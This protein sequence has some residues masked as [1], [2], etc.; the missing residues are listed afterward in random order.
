MKSF[1]A[2]Q[3]WFFCQTSLIENNK[4]KED[5]LR[6]H[7]HPA[8]CSR[9]EFRNRGKPQF[10]FTVSVL[11]TLTCITQHT[12]AAALRPIRKTKQLCLSVLLKDTSSVTGRIQYN[13]IRFNK[14]ARGTQLNIHRA[15]GGKRSHQDFFPKGGGNQ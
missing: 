14:L 3:L 5:L 9:R 8:G 6:A 13:T 2:W 7:I 1:C 15:P 11:G 10:S 12:V 4:N